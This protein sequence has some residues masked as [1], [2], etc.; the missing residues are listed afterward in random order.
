MRTPL[1]QFEILSIISLPIPITIT[2]SSIIMIIATG[3]IYLLYKSVNWSIIPSRWQSFL[4]IIYEQIITMV[5]ENLGKEGIEYFPFICSLFIYLLNLNLLG[6]I[7]YS[8]AVTS[9]AIITI[10]ISFSIWLGVL[11]SGIAKFGVNYAS[12][13]M[14][15]GAP[16]ILAPLLVMIEILS[17][18]ARAISLGLRL[19]ANITSGHIL[20]GIISG[21]GWT[22]LIGGGLLTIAGFFPILILLFLTILEIAVAVIQAYVYTLLV[23]IYLNDGLHLH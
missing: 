13:F 8:F 14:P 1:E 3:I 23:A 10:G 19:A 12:M 5:E 6:M 16:I 22:M 11:I 4:E 18:V 9:H 20:L 7:P 17:Y 2:N 21:F 15:H